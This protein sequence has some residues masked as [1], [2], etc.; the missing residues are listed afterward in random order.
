MWFCGDGTSFIASVGISVLLSAV[1]LY[2]FNIRLRALERTAQKQNQ[3]LSSFL[4]GMQGNLAHGELHVAGSREG[5]SGGAPAVGAAAAARCF[6]G[7]CLPDGGVQRVAVSDDEASGDGD[8]ASE[9]GSEYTESETGSDAGSDGVIDLGA[10]AAAAAGGPEGEPGVRVIELGMVAAEAGA[11]IAHSDDTGALVADAIEVLKGAVEARAEG[12][13][14]ADTASGEDGEEP[15][16][17]GES[18]EEVQEVQEVGAP[19]DDAEPVTVMDRL[20]VAELR[21][22]VIDKGLATT[23]EARGLKKA[24]LLELLEPA[25]GAVS[26]E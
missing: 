16:E 14:D 4:G 13:K 1:L 22:M 23:G 20:K 6:V 3:V 5:M 26:A 8:S 7:S 21:D 24:K 15:D 25:A 12:G 19:E 11:T 17:A 10:S 9:T 2:Y 18:A